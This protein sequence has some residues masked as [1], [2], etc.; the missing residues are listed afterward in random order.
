MDLF[1]FVLIHHSCY[2]Y[3]YLFRT[4]IVIS[5]KSRGIQQ[6]H[7]APFMAA[8]CSISSSYLFSRLFCSTIVLAISSPMNFDSSSRCWRRSGVIL[9]FLVTYNKRV[10]LGD[11]SAMISKHILI[12]WY[13]AIVLQ[14]T[15]P[16]KKSKFLCRIL[17]NRYYALRLDA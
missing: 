14:E 7:W 12:Y 10:V 3:G 5:L 4:G 9:H 6:L 11:S 8:R 2:G 16:V 1:I 15:S 13:N 17:H